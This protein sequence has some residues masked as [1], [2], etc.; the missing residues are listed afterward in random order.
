MR[1]IKTAPVYHGRIQYFYL[2]GHHDGDVYATGGDV[3]IALV[4]K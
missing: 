1:S 2:Y 3:E 4:S